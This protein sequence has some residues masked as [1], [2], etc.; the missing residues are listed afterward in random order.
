MPRYIDNALQ[1]FNHMRLNHSQNQPLNMSPAIMKQN[2]NMQNPRQT[3][4]LG[5]E[6]EIFI[7]QIM[8]V[9]LF[10]ERAVDSI[11]LV[12]LGAIS[13]EQANLTEETMKNVSNF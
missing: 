6:D 13:S 7:M 10:L 3:L 9:F 8:D 11:L 2:S 1:L 5:K 12:P 4:P